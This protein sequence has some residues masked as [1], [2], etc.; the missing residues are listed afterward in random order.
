MELQSLCNH[1]RVINFFYLKTSSLYKSSI[2]KLVKSSAHLNYFLTS[3][4]GLDPKLQLL[5][6]LSEGCI[7]NGLYFLLRHN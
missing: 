7:F 1:L 4:F 6:L 5:P 3:T 2:A